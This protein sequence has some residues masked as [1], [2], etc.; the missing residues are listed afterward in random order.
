V[1]LR[2]GAEATAGEVLQFLSTKMASWQVPDWV[3]FIDELPK[4]GVG[5]V[6]KRRLRDEVVPVFMEETG[7]WR[8]D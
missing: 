5:K 6:D 7:S 1:V 3:E 4:T 8:G 2:D